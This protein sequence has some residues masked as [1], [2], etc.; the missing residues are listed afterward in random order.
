MK[1]KYNLEIILFYTLVSIW[2]LKDR[3]PT[4]VGI[5]IQVS[6]TIITIW[7]VNLVIKRKK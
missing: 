5:L 4:S 6:L 7:L 3:V 1:Y 2:V